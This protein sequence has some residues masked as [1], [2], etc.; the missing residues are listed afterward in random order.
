MLTSMAATFTTHGHRL[1]DRLAAELCG[2][3][4]FIRV[5]MDG[6][7]LT[8]EKLRGRPFSALLNRLSVVRKL[9]PFGINFVVNAQTLPDLDEAVT[10]AGEIG[11]AEFLLLPEQPVHGRAGIDRHTT[12]ILHDWVATYEGPI[13]L[14]VSEAG[15]AGLPTCRPLAME[16]GLR[17]YAHIDASGR[18]KRSSY[19]QSGVSIGAGGVSE[20]LQILE[21]MLGSN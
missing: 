7:G 18:L 3:V 20:A 13:R 6:V 1:D 5:S 11:A 4:H 8:Y 2:N 12:Q 9:A 17:G 16:D 21:I 15:A 19:D 14:T 10:L